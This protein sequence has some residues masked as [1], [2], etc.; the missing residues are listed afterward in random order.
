[1]SD[2]KAR[3]IVQVFD[4]TPDHRGWHQ[5]TVINELECGWIYA[6]G[7]QDHPDAETALEVAG[8]IAENSGCRARAV[9][10]ATG[11]PVA[12]G[13]QRSQCL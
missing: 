1:M 4:P 9:D 10:M 2:T 6:V 7:D 5:V 8:L 13:L 12:A 11:Q 3:F